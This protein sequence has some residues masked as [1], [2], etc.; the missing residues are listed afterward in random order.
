MRLLILFL[1]LLTGCS[2][3]PKVITK[4]VK[5]PIYQKLE[6]PYREY[7]HLLVDELDQTS[8][9]QDVLKA[10]YIDHKTL[11]SEIRYYRDAV[12]SKEQTANDP[13]YTWSE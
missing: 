9:R 2:S 4:E 13:V 8:S 6:V 1:L 10:Y 12:Y 7:P 3:S 5:I 11:K